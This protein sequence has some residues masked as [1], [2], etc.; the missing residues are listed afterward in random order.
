MELGIDKQL[1]K[2]QNKKEEKLKEKEFGSTELADDIQLWKRF[3]RK[4]EKK[5]SYTILSFHL[6]GAPATPEAARSSW[7]G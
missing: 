2:K 7:P 5:N 1:W 3:R 6:I 4:E